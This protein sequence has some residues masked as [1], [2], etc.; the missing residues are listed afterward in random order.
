MIRSIL[1]CAL[2]L[3]PSVAFAVSVPSRVTI[4][5]CGDAVV[6]AGELCDE[7]VTGNIGQYASS[8]AERKCAPGCQ[9]FGPYCGDD[10]LQVRF[11]EQCDDGNNTSGDLC[12]AACIEELPVPPGSS[13]SPTVGSIPQTGAPPGNIP[14]AGETRVVLKGKAYPLSIVQV[15]LD[16]KKVGTAVAD[17]NAEFQ[18][19]ASNLTPGTATFGFWAMDPGG[20][21]SIT[22]SVVFEVVQSAVTTVG[23]ILLPPT[24][25]LS[26]TRVPPGGLLTVSGYAVPASK[27]VTEILPGRGD[28]VRADASATGVW[29]LQY[30]TGSLGVGFHTVKSY[31]EIG[32]SVKSGYGKLLNFFVGD[33]DPSGPSTSDLNGDSRINL[34]DFSIFLLGWGTD[35]PRSDFN[36]DGT[37]NLADF[38]IMLFGW[39]G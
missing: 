20:T 32:S 23:N 16:G 26:A 38:S 15:L 6:N 35:N 5:I 24:I 29:A 25:S 10:I 14:A 1:V 2:L 19:T 21:Q 4:S 3:L 36:G 11:T 33:Q 31:S 34:V 18:Y 27:V 30:D 17:A 8:T 12:T 39:T 22:S 28:G 9:A 37:T 7:G 13:G